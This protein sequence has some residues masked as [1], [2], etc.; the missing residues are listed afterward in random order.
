LAAPIRLTVTGEPRTLQFFAADETYL[1]ARDALGNA[2]RHSLGNEVVC[3]LR[4]EENELLLIAQDNGV[5][6]SDE[7]L[8]SGGKNGHWGLL[9]MR[10]R[11]RKIGARLTIV[12]RPSGTRI[13][14][15]VPGRSAFAVHDRGLLHRFLSRVIPA[16]K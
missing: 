13:E 3:E 2:M 11:A 1:I 9:G 12:S 5:G 10:E 15:R 16:R 7:T 14:L 8:A 6:I 4:Y